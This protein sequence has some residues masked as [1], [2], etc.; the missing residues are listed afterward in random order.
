MSIYTICGFG[1]KPGDLFQF[2]HSE[3]HNRGDSYFDSFTFY[4]NFPA[5]APLAGVV[6]NKEIIG[7]MCQSQA[8]EESSARCFQHVCTTIYLVLSYGPPSPSLLVN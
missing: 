1:I 5:G 6:C 8:K 2:Y 7:R 3:I 4:N